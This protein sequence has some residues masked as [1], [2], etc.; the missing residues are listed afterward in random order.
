MDHRNRN[1]QSTEYRL[2]ELLNGFVIEEKE[3]F[4]PHLSAWHPFLGEP[5]STIIGLGDFEQGLRIGFLV[6]S[7][8]MLGTYVLSLRY[9]SLPSSAMTIGSPPTTARS[10]NST[11][12]K[13]ARQGQEG[14]DPPSLWLRR[15]RTEEELH[16]P[17]RNVALSTTGR[18]RMK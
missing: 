4:R 12:R 1:F 16:S 2:Q 17:M 14:L 7:F 3:V 11:C 18:Y 9:R 15:S 10:V 6:S 8:L 13:K 5:R